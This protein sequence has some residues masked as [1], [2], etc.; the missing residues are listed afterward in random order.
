M[1]L[2]RKI[3]ILSL[4][5]TSLL[6]TGCFNTAFQEKIEEKQ[7]EKEQAKKASAEKK[8]EK[9]DKENETYEKLAK[10]LDEVINE[11]DL[12]TGK[13]ITPVGDVKAKNSYENSGDFSIYVAD[14]LYKFYTQ[15]ISPEQYYEFL[16]KYGSR[17]TVQ[18]LPSKE[19]AI[20]ILGSLQGLYKSKNI[21]GESYVLTEIMLGRLK[22]EGHFYRKVITTNGEEYFISTIAKEDG[23]WKFVEDSPSPPFEEGEVAAEETQANS[24]VNTEPDSATETTEETSNNE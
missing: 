7:K 16:T 13:I 11:S 9:K 1:K 15:Q 8:A 24:E 10:P 17:S 12:D 21:Q 4:L 2:H 23:A 20:T 18:E 22:K 3:L 5:T 6:M 14:V 19:D